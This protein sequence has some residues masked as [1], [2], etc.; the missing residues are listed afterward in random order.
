MLAAL[1]LLSVERSGAIVEALEQA[2][3]PEEIAQLHRWAEYYFADGDVETFVDA[4][5]ELAGRTAEG[6]M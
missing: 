2:S 5:L 6:T 4:V 1:P 3:G